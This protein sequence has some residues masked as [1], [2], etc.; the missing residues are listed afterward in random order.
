MNK[1]KER[2]GQMTRETMSYLREADFAT[3][4]I[5]RDGVN[6]EAWDSFIPDRVSIKRAI[7]G[8]YF[9]TEFEHYFANLWNKVENSLR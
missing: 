3:D 5:K 4:I 2:V 7:P 1:A 8:Q 6:I 9:P